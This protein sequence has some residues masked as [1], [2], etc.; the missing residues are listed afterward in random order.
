M[1]TPIARSP[2]SMG[3]ISAAGTWWSTK[4]VR[5]LS[6]A[7]AAV[8][9]AATVVAEAA[10]VFGVLSQ[11]RWQA[12]RLPRFLVAGLHRNVTLLAVAFVVAHVITTVADTFAPIGYQD[13]LL[14][15]LSPYR[16]LWLGLGTVA[17]SGGVFQNLLLLRETERRLA[18]RGFTVLTHFQVPC[19]DGGISLG[20]AVVAGLGRSADAREGIAY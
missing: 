6:A 16:P 20:Q 1:K 2:L 4:R 18:A 7:V 10:V 8:A 19:N 15:F 3:R 11:V 5:R 12:R 14:P 13:A 17:L 9:A